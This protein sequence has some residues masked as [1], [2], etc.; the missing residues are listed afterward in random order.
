MTAAPSGPSEGN[1]RS[2]NVSL[3]EQARRVFDGWTDPDT[4]VHVLRIFARG[5][6]E[7]REALQTVYHQQRCFLDGGRKVLLR[8]GHRSGNGGASGVLMD[9][10]TGVVERPFPESHYV[11]EVM[12]STGIA[13]LRAG[14]RGKRQRALLWDLQARRELASCSIDGWRYGGASFL[15]D[16]RR[17]LV[18]WER[19][20]PYEGH[21]ES[22]IVLIEPEAQPRTVLEADG[23]RCN[24]IQGCPTQ[25]DLFSYDR[26][27]SPA[28]DVDQVIHLCTLD[29]SYHEPL[30]LSPEALRPAQM[31]GVRD[32]YVWTP[33]GR[34]IVSY[35]FLHPVT[36]GGDFNHFKFE[37]W[38]SALDRFTGDDLAAKYPPGRW[39]GHMHVT[40]DS[41]YMICGGG[42][43]F[44]KL[45]A[46]DIEALR[47][48]WNE[49]I[50]CSYPQTTSPGTNSDPFPYPFMLP[51]GSG[52]IFNAGWPGPEHGVY[53]AEWKIA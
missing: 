33:D 18:A 35:L 46:V 12:D 48:G 15:S 47:D 40:H 49:H 44:D 53:L 22:R 19:G 7:P 39:G 26:W 29:G 10:T 43:G 14:A 8:S 4:G 37:W 25:P 45:F 20:K 36:H 32:H 30:K 27:P 24:H 21:T 42:P 38:L 3:F 28:R 31:W 13:L 2:E 51:D 41:R 17:A 23:Y 16:G 52:V 50:I 6:R 1:V 34:R 9:L 11:S 5:D